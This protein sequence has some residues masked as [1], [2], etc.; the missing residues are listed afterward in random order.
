MAFA[1]PVNAGASHLVTMCGQNITSGGT[2]TVANDIGPCPVSGTGP[3][4]QAGIQI[5]HSGVT[6]NV[7]GHQITGSDTTNTTPNEQVGIVLANVQ[8]VVVNGQNGSISGFDAGLAVEGGGHNNVNGLIV[9]DNIAHVDET[10]GVPGSNGNPQQNPCNFGDGILTDNSSNNVISNNVA[11]HN[12][13]FS[14][15]ALVDNSLG[16]LVTQNTAS[17]QTVP[18]TIGL[19]ANPT[20][21]TPGPC[22]PFGANIVGPG[23]PDQDEGIR[24]EGPGAQ[25][26][27]VD[28]NSSWGNML[29][30]IAVHSH[31][32]DSSPSFGGPPPTGDNSYNTVS[33]NQAF[34]DGNDPFAAHMSNGIALLQQGPAGVVCTSDHETLTGNTVYNNANDGIYLGGRDSGFNIVTNN[35]AHNNYNNGVE[36]IARSMESNGNFQLG[37]NNDT[38]TSNTVTANGHDGF[39]DGLGATNNAY[40]QNTATGNH[41]NTTTFTTG[42]D[43]EDVNTACDSN[44]WNADTFGTV[45]QSCIH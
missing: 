4:L 32:C 25:H 43:A 24:I 35:S 15:I 13:P 7:A 3:A 21:Y 44:A 12:G 42:Y 19:S 17:R 34:D 8:K 33:N 16:N 26:N 9:Q 41:T 40:S 22:G 6:L 37:S 5:S 18:N 20:S 10:G 27:T 28:N 38:I 1:I 2:W 23:R 14:G 11:T 29:E 36:L 31:V 30:G 45:S 39:L